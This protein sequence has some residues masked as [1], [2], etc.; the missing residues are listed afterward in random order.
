M[1]DADRAA[2]ATAIDVDDEDAL[3]DVLE[4]FDGRSYRGRAYWVFPDHRHGLERGTVVIGGEVVRGFPKIHRT[5]VLDP[6]IPR[7]FEGETFAEEKLNGYNVRIT[8]VAAFGDPIALTRSGLICP[9]TTD[10][11]RKLLDLDPFFDAHPDLF[12][13]GELVGAENPYTPHEYPEVDSHDLFVFDVRDRMTGEPLP[14]EER[15]ALVDSFGF[16]QPE[17]HARG[18]AEA[19]A[20][21]LQAVIEELDAA[22]REG[23][24]I[25]SA[26]GKTQM[27]YT[28][29][30]SNRND[31]AH[32]FALPFD[33]GQAFLFSRIVREGFQTVEFDENE[34][35][36][37]ERA[38]DLGE[39]IL[40]PLAEAIETVRDG[41]G[42][43][44][45]HTVR[46]DPAVI[47]A[48]FD[49]LENQ[50]LQIDVREETPI[51][52]GAVI[53]FEKHAPASTDKIQSYLAGHTY[54]E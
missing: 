4:H 49:H 40:L 34:E 51:D 6:G 47:H 2:L 11:T 36:R 27:K 52:D 39:S 25:K 53:E 48:L 35:A 38:R 33:Y 16:R 46:G 14:V 5:L 37:R 13:C 9:Y 12:L 24:V 7:H 3:E 10:R 42:V 22:G 23:V 28:A 41:E 8:D 1:E 20:G 31:L 50:G 18:P 32:A 26:D 17:I 29:G 30:Q 15:R 54:A 44:E 45:T 21:D 19:L 43:G